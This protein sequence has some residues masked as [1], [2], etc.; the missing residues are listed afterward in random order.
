M[1]GYGDYI[2]KALKD[3][4]NKELN[5]EFQ[6]IAD[7]LIITN[8]FDML[9]HLLKVIKTYEKVKR[10]YYGLKKTCE[11]QQYRLYGERNRYRG[12]K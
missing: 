3:A 8:S 2:A 7:R 11:N 12:I 5:D 10:D 1:M 6:A 4:K 9:P